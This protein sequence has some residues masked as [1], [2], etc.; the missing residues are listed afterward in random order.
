MFDG[1]LVHLVVVILY[2][3]AVLVLTEE[4]FMLLWL[5]ISS[6][7]TLLGLTEEWFMLLIYC[8]PL[9]F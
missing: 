6:T 4:W 5:V 8:L 7:I 3:I 1:G 9:L 2:T